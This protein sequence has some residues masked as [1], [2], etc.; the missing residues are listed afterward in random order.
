MLKEG[1]SAPS[2]V[3]GVEK[4]HSQSV[5]VRQIQAIHSRLCY[6]DKKYY[7]V[8]ELFKEKVSK[9]GVLRPIVWSDKR[10]IMV[11]A[12]RIQDTFPGMAEHLK[13]GETTFEI[14]AGYDKKGKKVI[15]TLTGKT[16][17]K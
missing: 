1:K 17:A 10:G 4:V 16:P 3:E 7:D 15:F 11:S 12:K 9:A 5:N 14:E 2:I 8:P 6:R 13:G